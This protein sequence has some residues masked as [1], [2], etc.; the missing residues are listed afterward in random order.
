M[1]FVLGDTFAALLLQ[2]MTRSRLHDHAS[3]NLEALLP[4]H[5][6]PNLNRYYLKS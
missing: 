2:R 3:N 4:L 1:A 6:V 5:T